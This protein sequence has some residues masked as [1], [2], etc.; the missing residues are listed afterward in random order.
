[1]R[2]V[3]IGEC[4]VEPSET[5][6]DRYAR[7]FAGDAYNTAVYL[8]R[9]APEAEVEFLTATGEGELSRAV[10]AAW[11]GAGVSDAQAYVA[12][13]QEPGLYMIELDGRSDSAARRWPRLMEA[14]GGAVRLA[15]AD[16]VFLSGISP[17]ILPAEDRA[18]AIGRLSA[19]KGKVGKIALDL[20]ARPTLWE[21]LNDARAPLAAAMGITDIVRA[22][23]GDAELL[24]AASAPTAQMQALQ[25][26]GPGEIV[27]TLDAD[28]C[29]VMSGGEVT[30]IQQLFDV[31]VVGATGA[32][33]CLNGVYL[34]QKL[35]GEPPVATAQAALAI[36]ARKIG[37]PD[38]IVPARVTHPR[39]A[40]R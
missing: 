11:A 31:K 18:R 25:A 5:G 7:S 39:A 30:A 1:M 9:T 28:G 34:E 23:R 17:A 20:N 12:P 29:L 22:S 4:M 13:E 37:A 38:A 19:L 3:A 27:L 33:D 40:R 16:L 2:A 32:E 10:R 24:F 26:A 6:D 36:A 35:L 14:D 8:K 15:E 21:G